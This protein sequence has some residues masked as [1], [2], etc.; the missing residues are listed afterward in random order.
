MA[1]RR[2]LKAAI[3]HLSLCPR[4]MNRL[5]V[6][7]KSDDGTVDFDTLVKA[8]S[9]FAENGELTA[10]VYAP[11]LRD[12]EG[13][14]A[15]SQ[16][17]KEAMYDAS[18]RGI[19]LD[20]RHNFQA[21]PK[22]RAYI[23]ESFIVQKGDPRFC[24]MKDYEGNAV[25][26]TGGWAVVVK[27]DDPALRK[28]YSEGRWNGVSMAGTGTFE[29]EKSDKALALLEQLL[30]GQAVPAKAPVKEQ[31]EMTKEEIAA[32]IAESNKIVL[33]EVAKMLT[34][35]PPE[36]KKEAGE[37]ILKE[38][39]R[40]NSV[41]IRKH[42]FAVRKYDL[43]KGV[44]WADTESVNAYLADLA[45]LQK[46][47]AEALA[48]IKKQEDAAKASRQIAGNETTPTAPVLKDDDLFALGRKGGQAANIQRP[49][50]GFKTPTE[51]K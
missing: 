18:K 25:D 45:V 42:L 33:A 3:T 7:Y 39:D 6:I 51:V 47:E 48:E 40:E 50:S 26:V 12:R 38:S 10:V 28:E 31:E 1:K 19:A 36:I 37:P 44:V 23:A 8:D 24:S 4:G 43:K 32:M 17:I 2:L 5:P 20:I 9:K 16:V 22:D 15:S 14:I 30:N 11:E 49:I 41:A 29:V 34:P 35:K 27:I 21:I 46:E 13:D